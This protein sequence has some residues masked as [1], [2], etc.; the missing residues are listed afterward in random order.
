MPEDPD[1][2]AVTLWPKVRSALQDLGL[3]VTISG[4]T[5]YQLVEHKVFWTLSIAALVVFAVWVWVRLLRRTRQPTDEHLPA[6][7]TTTDIL[8]G[9]EG[10]QSESRPF[11][12]SKSNRSK[13]TKFESTVRVLLPRN[14]PLSAFPEDSVEFG[15]RI[16]WKRGRI[17]NLTVLCPKCR[18]VM[19]FAPD[20]EITGRTNRTLLSCPKC[21][22][23]CSVPGAPAEFETAAKQE[24]YKVTREQRP[25]Q[26]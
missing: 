11:L 2:Q 21:N 10:D 9:I 8:K 24:L 13:P 23:R 6:I 17:S 22:F 5:L 15:F 7:I 14:N 18:D 20:E 3:I 25:H 19:E 16:R 1:K 4:F 12:S 26:E